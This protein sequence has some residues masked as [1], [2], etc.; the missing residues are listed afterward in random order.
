MRWIIWFALLAVFWMFEAMAL[1]R[2]TASSAGSTVMLAS[3][4][5]LGVFLGERRRRSRRCGD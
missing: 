1:G 2:D 5:S 4:A 3:G